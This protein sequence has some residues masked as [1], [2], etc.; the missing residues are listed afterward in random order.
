MAIYAWS[1]ISPETEE[2]LRNGP[3]REPAQW[4]ATSDDT[5]REVN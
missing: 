4:P 3:F 2:L 1:Y 5:G